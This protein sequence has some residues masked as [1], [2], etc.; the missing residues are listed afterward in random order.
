MKQTVSI[1]GIEFERINISGLMLGGRAKYIHIFDN[2]IQI[3]IIE[4]DRPKAPSYICKFLDHQEL[5]NIKNGGLIVEHRKFILST[6]EQFCYSKEEA[7]IEVYKKYKNESRADEDFIKHLSKTEDNF[8]I[9]DIL[10]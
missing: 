6:C 4:Y 7:L 2:K 5:L 9:K 1:L 10:E 8:T 3:E